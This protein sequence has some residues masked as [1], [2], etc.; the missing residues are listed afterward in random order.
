MD[1]QLAKRLMGTPRIE[2]DSARGEKLIDFVAHPAMSPKP[3]W[4]KKQLLGDSS[5]VA[6]VLKGN[7]HPANCK[8][9]LVRCHKS[10]EMNWRDRW[11]RP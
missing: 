5:N 4:E 1:H 6:I 3:R 7:I 9:D 2:L 10:R 8:V 11:G